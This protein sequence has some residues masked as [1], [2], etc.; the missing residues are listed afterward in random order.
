MKRICSIV[1][2]FVDGRYGFDE[3]NKVALW[4]SLIT[5]LLASVVSDVFWSYLLYA[6][7]I[8]LLMYVWWLMLSTD[9]SRRSAEMEHLNYL[10][11]RKKR[12]LWIVK[13]CL[14]VRKKHG[15]IVSIK[16]GQHVCVLNRRETMNSTCKKTVA[17]VLSAVR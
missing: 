2:K 4:C 9:I 7:S 12:K 10:F 11:C 17:E 13:R 8:A 16:C 3:R 5:V 6:V 1:Q 15:S 14:M